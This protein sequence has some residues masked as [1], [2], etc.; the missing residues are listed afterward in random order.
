[1]ESKKPMNY[2]VF[3]IL[4]MFEKEC[5]LSLE[6]MEKSDYI[7]KVTIYYKSGAE[8]KFREIDLYTLNFHKTYFRGIY[9]EI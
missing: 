8:K 7:V 3:W 6:E 1:M 9:R 2:Y 4:I 5:L